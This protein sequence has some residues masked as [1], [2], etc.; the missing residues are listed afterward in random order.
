MKESAMGTEQTSEG[1]RVEIAHEAL[2]S[3]WPQLQQVLGERCEADKMRHRV[4]AKTE[5]YSEY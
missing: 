4:E 2:I 3:G 5:T 1:R